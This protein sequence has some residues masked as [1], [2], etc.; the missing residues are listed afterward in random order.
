L[1][2]KI[3]L[4]EIREHLR[5]SLWAV[6]TLA[7]VLAI[8]LSQILLEIDRQYDLVDPDETRFLF[9]GTGDSAGQLLATIAM[10]ILTVTGVIFSVTIL[11][12]Q[13]ASQQLSPRV[14]RTFLRDTGTQVVLGTFIGTFLYSLLVL[15]QVR[16]EDAGD[17]F[18]PSISMA[19]ALA[20]VLASLGLFIYFINHVAQSIR[21]ST[22]I[23]RIADE[24]RKAIEHAYPS[25][26]ANEPRS[27]VNRPSGDAQAV[28]AKRGQGGAL[29]DIDHGRLSKVARESGCIIEIVPVIGDFV[30]EGGDV[31]R[32][33]GPVDEIEEGSILAAIGFNAERS[34]EQDPAFGLRQLVDIGER[35]LS[36]GVNDPTTAIQALDRIHDLLGRLIE[37]DFPS[38]YRVDDDGRLLLILHRPD[39]DDYVA[40]GL[41]ELRIYGGGS[42][43]V[44]RR[45]RFIVEDLLQVAREDRRPPLR[46]Q[47][48]LLE[49]TI[50]A[51][52]AVE[53]DRA[54]ASRGS[55]QG[56]GPA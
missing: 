40:L 56:H 30:R 36:T 48:I 13:Q 47:L 1:T 32:V 21:P 41:D 43:Q 51:G 44:M 54:T 16:T 53:Q 34:M 5:S 42:I 52:L 22:V 12:L 31:A 11:V 38:E 4:F 45:I 15:R 33:W 24:T 8:L 28:I 14:L 3:R 23:G 25:D 35:A 17:R 9:A 49:A 50:E 7:V 29:T 39:W 10:A 2:A 27:T 55:R 6:P 37:V 20:L 19:L 26:A 46:R 18:V